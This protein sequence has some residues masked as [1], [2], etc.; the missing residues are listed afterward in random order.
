MVSGIGVVIFLVTLL[1][2]SHL[3]GSSEYAVVHK[4]YLFYVAVSLLYF[5]FSF[6][7][8]KSSR[9]K[10]VTV[11]LYLFLLIF[12]GVSM[13]MTDSSNASVCFIV[14][15]IVL[16]LLLVARPVVLVP[17]VLVGIAAA[18]TA[19]ALTQEPNMHLI[20]MLDIIPCGILSMLLIF[21][22]MR[23][24]M[25]RFYYKF[26]NQQLQ[27]S[28][29]KALDAV[30]N[31]ENFVGAL[32]RS[33]SEEADLDVAIE[34]L[35]TEIGKKLDTDRVYIF[36]RNAVGTF[37]VT[38]EWWREGV[39]SRRDELKNIPFEGVIETWYKAFDDS[40]C[41]VI[42]D[43]EDYKNVN[44]DI[45]ELLKSYG[46]KSLI[47]RPLVVDGE[48]IGYL[49]V[50][51][52]AP[53]MRDYITSL[54][55]MTEFFISAIIR[56]RNNI[57]ILQNYAIYD[58]LTNCKNRAAMG[59]LLGENFDKKDSLGLLLCDCNGLKIA[60]DTY[61]HE[62]GDSLIIRTSRTLQS[63]FG[64]DDLYRIG[65]DEFVVAM[66]GISRS[67]FEAL[68]KKAEERLG[69]MASVGY[70]FNETV[71]TDIVSILKAADKKMYQ[72]KRRFYE[73]RKDDSLQI[74]QELI[75]TE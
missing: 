15:I 51:N 57:R 30:E 17:I 39:H 3:N 1:V 8:I 49:G 11:Y 71:E 59:W 32:V 4:L 25:R 31:V 29:Q 62:V 9:I 43:I 64:S 18:I 5:C 50:D 2:S 21:V 38:Y 22:I 63:I 14:P 73:K 45:Y 13:L 46:T 42:E 48:R 36:E 56:V 65:G 70:V 68:A 20:N 75:E 52:P 47:A 61:G 12:F 58:S 34:K 10:E 40:S 54:L 37:D 7:R 60:N 28:E 23:N 67:E 44:R 24:R 53:E 16:P 55:D 26:E 6:A 41:M 33:A 72:Q 74:L 27:E 19:S 66:S 35:V 69:D